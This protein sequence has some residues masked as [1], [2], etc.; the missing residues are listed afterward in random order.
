[1]TKDV[2]SGL[3]LG[4]ILIVA[5]VFAVNGLPKFIRNQIPAC[6]SATD[7]RN[8]IIMPEKV[9]DD[10]MIIAKETAQNMREQ[11]RQIDTE[12]KIPESAKIS[13]INSQ[14]NTTNQ[15]ENNE[16]YAAQ[17]ENL[18]TENKSEDVYVVKS[19]D[20]LASIAKKFYGEQEGNRI[21]NI[22]K[23]AEHNKLKSA[24]HIYKGQKLKIPPLEKIMQSGEFVRVENFNPSSNSKIRT[25][26]PIPQLSTQ[27]VQ[28]T[29]TVVKG[30]TLWSISEKY[31]GSGKRLSEILSLNS[32]LTSDGQLEVGEV[33][34][35]P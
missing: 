26:T 9:S 21:V 29:Y 18:S 33:I 4:F 5:I 1:M 8:Q 10:L 2:K 19:N 6:A 35:L 22:K 15:S 28:K 3:L 24:D 23:I 32:Q 31:L 20:N 14:P 17:P 34:L 30:D 11:P 13:N 7:N 25:I 27:V 12:I 16:V